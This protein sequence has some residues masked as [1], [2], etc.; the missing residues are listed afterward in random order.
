LLTV[1]L[2]VTALLGL[3]FLGIKAYEYYSKYAEHLVPGARFRA[4]GAGGPRLQIFLFLYFA[5]TGLH[6]AH[7]V[8]GLGALGWLLVLNARGRLSAA[9]VEPVVMVGLYWHFVD[10]IWVF[11]YPLFY[12]AGR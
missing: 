6:A 7:M 4:S 9:R 8:C 2:A 11:L 3:L 10:C 1:C 12:L 5:M